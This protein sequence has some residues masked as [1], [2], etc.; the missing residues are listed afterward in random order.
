MVWRTINS[1]NKRKTKEKQ[2]EQIKNNISKIKVANIQKYFPKS[3]TE[4]ISGY[5][6]GN[7]EEK[8]NIMTNFFLINS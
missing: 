7:F 6:S 8:K 5:L 2:I 4:N 1:K 3:S